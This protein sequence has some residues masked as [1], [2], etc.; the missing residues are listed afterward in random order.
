[1]PFSRGSSQPRDQTQI[2]C[3]AGR[4][5]TIWA[6]REPQ[7]H[8]PGIWDKVYN[9]RLMEQ[10]VDW[11]QDLG[12]KILHWLPSIFY[13]KVG[14]VL[15][16]SITFQRNGSQLLEKDSPGLNV[17]LKNFTFWKGRAKIYNYK[18]S[19]INNLFWRGPRL[20]ARLPWWLRL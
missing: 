13:L 15:S 9:S 2:S 5:F 1:M 7:G 3:I 14:S 8:I 11:K 16:L 6:T 18:N 17:P 20:R 4:Y 19:E 12:L 10:D